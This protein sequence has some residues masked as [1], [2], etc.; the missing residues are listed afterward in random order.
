MLCITYYSRLETLPI[1]SSTSQICVFVDPWQLQLEIM[2]VSV[3]TFDYKLVALKNLSKI[4]KSKE[5]IES[6]LHKLENMSKK[7]TEVDNKQCRVEERLNELEKWH[8]FLGS[9]YDDQQN[10][11]TKISKENKDLA[12]ENLLL[13]KK[14]RTLEADLDKW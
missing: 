13:N 6:Q 9:K 1:C 14:I 7:V 8:E 11:L 3:Y 2:E 10:Q 5:S 4:T 12:K